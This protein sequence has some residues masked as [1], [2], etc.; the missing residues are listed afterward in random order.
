MNHLPAVCSHRCDQCLFSKNKIVSNKRREQI[1]R[2]CLQNDQPFL[3][4]KGSIAGREHLYC[5]GFV[6]TYPGYG[7]AIRL[8]TA[9]GILTEA[10]PEDL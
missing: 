8:A 9:L 10:N 2:E 6:E 4:H 3:C 1:I 7:Q 5:R